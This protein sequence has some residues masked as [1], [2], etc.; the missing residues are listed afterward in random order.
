VADGG[1]AL[2]AVFRLAQRQGAALR[3]V[4]ENGVGGQILLHAADGLGVPDPL[5]VSPGDLVED[6]K[7]LGQQ[8]VLPQGL[9]L[10][11]TIAEIGQQVAAVVRQRRD[12]RVHQVVEVFG[13]PVG[14]LVVGHAVVQIDVENDVFDLIM[15]Q[16][17]GRELFAVEHIGVIH[18]EIVEAG[19]IEFVQGLRGEGAGG[20]ADRKSTRLNSSHV[21]I[22]YA[23]FC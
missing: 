1:Y 7:I 10:G 23:V 6:V 12:I 11:Q 9:E 22:S 3:V 19:V 18:D 13:Q 17:I 21:S 15:F 20:G 4:G 8:G 14:L 5:V 2:H 16:Q